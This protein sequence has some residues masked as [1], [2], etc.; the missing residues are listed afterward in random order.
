MVELL[1]HLL[2]C[3]YTLRIAKCNDCGKNLSTTN[4]LKEV[5]EHVKECPS[6]LEECKFC[7]LPQP[8]NNMKEHFKSCPEY[9][10]K[11]L[12]CFHEKKRKEEHIPESCLKKLKVLYQTKEAKSKMV[13]TVVKETKKE[14]KQ[15]K[16]EVKYFKSNNPLI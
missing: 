2:V 9:V 15:L 11:C 12:D 14:M 16:D 3:K 5:A 6:V 13:L 4:E 10:I 8:R 1:D 7:N